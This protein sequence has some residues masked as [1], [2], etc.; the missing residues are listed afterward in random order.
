[1]FFIV[2]IEQKLFKLKRKRLDGDSK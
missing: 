2:H 1:L